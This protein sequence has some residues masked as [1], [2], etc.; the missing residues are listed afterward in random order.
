VHTVIRQTLDP[1]LQG[2]LQH[3]WKRNKTNVKSEAN[4]SILHHDFAP[5]FE[6]IFEQGVQ[7]G[8][9]DVD[10]TLEKSVHFLFASSS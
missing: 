2:T 1:S 5:G 9:Y 10:N 3:R 4:W 6:D 7:E 8:W